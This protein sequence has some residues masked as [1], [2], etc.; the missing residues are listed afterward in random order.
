MSLKKY[1]EACKVGDLNKLLLMLD[2]ARDEIY[3]QIVDKC[4]AWS[5]QYNKF[6]I[7]EEMLNLGA[8]VSYSSTMPNKL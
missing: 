8:N 1:A 7:S 5:L 2:S 3:W 4:L 6:N